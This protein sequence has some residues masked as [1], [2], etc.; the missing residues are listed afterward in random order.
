MAPSRLSRKDIFLGQESYFF[1]Y[2]QEDG[3]YGVFKIKTQRFIR[4]DLLCA[5]PHRPRF[6][7]HWDHAEELNKKKRFIRG[8]LCIPTINVKDLQ[9]QRLPS[10]SSTSYRS[11]TLLTIADSDSQSSKVLPPLI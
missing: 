5:L 9:N 8:G 11:V 4:R 1:P 10:T 6:D 2:H 7:E 3:Q